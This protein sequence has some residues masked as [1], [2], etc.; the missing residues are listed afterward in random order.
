MVT[1]GAQIFTEVLYRMVGRGVLW[2]EEEIASMA[3]YLAQVYGPESAEV[4]QM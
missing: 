3:E 2:T 4:P 1:R